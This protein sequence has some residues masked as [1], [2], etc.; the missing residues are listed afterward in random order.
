[1]PEEVNYKD[2]FFESRDALVV[3]LA[4]YEDLTC[5]KDTPAFISDR[6]RVVAFAN[7]YDIEFVFNIYEKI[8]DFKM[9]R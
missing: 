5:E 2:L 3:L 1:M 6:E 8:K 4:F 7:N 9:H